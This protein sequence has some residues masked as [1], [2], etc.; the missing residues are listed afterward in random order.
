MFF[1]S[2]MSFRCPYSQIYEPELVG[3]PLLQKQ[4]YDLVYDA[5][6]AAI[7]ACKPGV[8]FREIG[9]IA[10]DIINEG[11]AELEIIDSASQRHMY[12]PHGLS[13]HIGLDVHD[14]GTYDKLETNMAI[15]VE[16]GIYI[17]EGSNCDK[18]WWKIAVRIEDDVLIT[19]DGFELLSYMA[20]RK[21]VEIEELMKQPSPLDAF[22]LP[23]LDEKHK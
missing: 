15:T 18:K 14:K 12:Y 2:T 6:E 22:M 3:D 10:R 9:K 23:V 20:P 21:S 4:I 7:Q 19:A 11:L 1:A 8:S 17:P 16:P 5:Q 13:H